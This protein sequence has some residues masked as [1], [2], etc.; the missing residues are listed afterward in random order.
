M[1]GFV[2]GI[3]GGVGTAIWAVPPLLNRFSIETSPGFRKL[4]GLEESN[5]GGDGGN[6]NRL[7]LG[8]CLSVLA[9]LG[10]LVESSIK[11]R[12]QS[13]DSGS[14]LPGH[15]GILDRFDSSLLAVLFYRVVLEKATN[16]VSEADNTYGTQS[17]TG[18]GNFEL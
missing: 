5:D 17:L 14:V 11:R 16:L 10:D 18:R 6:L 8:F 13:K 1:E 2:G 4:W 15:G 12:S 9:I 7:L 3:V